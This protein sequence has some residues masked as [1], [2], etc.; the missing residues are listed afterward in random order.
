MTRRELFRIL[1]ERKL[2]TKYCLAIAQSFSDPMCYTDIFDN[3]P[4]TQADEYIKNIEQIEDET[5][6]EK[7]LNSIKNNWNV[8]YDKPMIQY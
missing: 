1:K 3:K 2:F 6:I 4:H 5:R 7:Y 8:Y